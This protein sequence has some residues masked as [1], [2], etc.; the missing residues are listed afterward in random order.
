MSNECVR[1]IVAINVFV[2]QKVIILERHSNIIITI[3]QRLYG[4]C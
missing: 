3:W 2:W 1:A 4:F